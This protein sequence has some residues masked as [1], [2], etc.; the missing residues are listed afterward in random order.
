[1]CPDLTKFHDEQ[2]SALRGL[3][4]QDMEEMKRQHAEQI[5][6]LTVSRTVQC[7]FLMPSFAPFTVTVVVVVVVVVVVGVVVVVYV[8]SLS[9][10]PC[11]HV[12]SGP[13]CIAC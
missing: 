5:Q 1:M 3:H 6:S 11:S 8:L 13:G 4:Q 9:W 7:L 10:V 2:L 12:M